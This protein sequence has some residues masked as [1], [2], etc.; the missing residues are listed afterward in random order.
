MANDE[1]DREPPIEPTDRS[2]VGLDEGDS[3]TVRET[4]VAS[5]RT[6]RRW[7]PLMVGVVCVLVLF[8][9]LVYPQV[10]RGFFFPN[11]LQGRNGT[12]P[13]LHRAHGG[14]PAR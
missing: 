9:Y 4:P 8:G 14:L 3:R 13:A 6:R 1:L 12:R 11:T 5:S 2:P 10:I 7:W